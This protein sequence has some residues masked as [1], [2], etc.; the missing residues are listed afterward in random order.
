VENDLFWFVL[1]FGGIWLVGRWSNA[2][3]A[4]DDAEKLR[5]REECWAIHSDEIKERL[6]RDRAEQ[7]SMKGQ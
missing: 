3:E 1:A 2:K 4:R 7:D 6:R 5:R